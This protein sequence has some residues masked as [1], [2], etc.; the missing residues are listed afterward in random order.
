LSSCYESYL[1]KQGRT[2]QYSS[3]WACPRANNFLLDGQEINDV[4]IGGRAF[5]PNIP[6]LAALTSLS[7][8][9]FGRAGGGVVNLISK[10]G[11]NQFHGEVFERYTGSGLNALGGQERGTGATKATT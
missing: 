5:Q 1:R 10:A 7:S 2:Y 4:G 8:A 9:E 11:T 3:Q 6:T